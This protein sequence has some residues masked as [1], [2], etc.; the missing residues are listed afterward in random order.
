M[1]YLPV[2]FYYRMYNRIFLRGCKVIIKLK[3]RVF[4]IAVAA[5]GYYNVLAAK[6]LFKLFCSCVPPCFGGFIIIQGIKIGQ[7]IAAKQ[8]YV[9]GF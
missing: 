9:I 8:G 6:L 1:F 5:V 2:Q 7:V 3:K 4:K